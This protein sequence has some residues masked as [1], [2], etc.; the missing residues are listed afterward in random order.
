MKRLLLLCSFLAVS[1]CWLDDDDDDSTNPIISPPVS[2]PAASLRVLHGSPDAPN[3]DVLI[4]G[5]TVLSDVPYKTASDYLAVPADGFDISVNVAGTTDTALAVENVELVPDTEHTIIAANVVAELEAIVLEDTV[6]DPAAGEL[7]VRAVHAA[8][9]APPVN[10]YVTEPDAELANE[11]PAV[12]GAAFRDASDFLMIPAADYRVRITAAGAPDVLFDSGTV[13]L[14][15]GDKLTLVALESG[16]NSLSPVTLVALTGDP[17]NPSTEIADDRARVRAAHL[18]PDAPNVDVLV[19]GEVVLADVP[20]PTVSEYLE[21]GSGS[22]EVDIN[23]AGTMTSVLSESLELV[24]GD[25]FT[26]AAVNFLASLEALVIEDD[27]TAP[28]PGNAHL[29]V[30]HASPDAPNVDVLV[31]D[32]IVLE[33]V[34]FKAASDYLPLAAGEYN[35]KVNA[36]GTATTVIDVTPTL[37]DGAIYTVFAANEL[38]SIEPILV[39]DN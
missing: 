29:R 32:E 20:F 14:E 35:I 25:V 27:L 5:E 26:F 18:S 1:G 2:G 17:E 31:D 22:Y 9:A 11:T 34:P 4:D 38:A 3:V 24:G 13:P 37:E 7:A 10:I 28:E 19:D 16:A 15:E 30:V 6:T 36:T 21:L 39:Q 8:P 23:Q 33:D 12:A